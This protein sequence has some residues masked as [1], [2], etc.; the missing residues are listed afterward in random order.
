M[1]Q[2]QIQQESERTDRIVLYKVHKESGLGNIIRGYVTAL[3]LGSLTNRAVESCIVWSGSW[4]VAF[5]RD[6]F[7]KF[8]FPPFPNMSAKGSGWDV[9]Y[10]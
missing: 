4:L 10:R 6:S 9:P 8:F 5:P 2:N 7:F 1:K 3:A